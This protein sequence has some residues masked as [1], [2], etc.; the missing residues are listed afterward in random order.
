MTKTTRIRLHILSLLTVVGLAS[1]AK[2]Q[3]SND[4]GAAAADSAA[5]DSIQPIPESAIVDEVIW[6][7]GDEAILKSDVEEAVYLPILVLARS[8]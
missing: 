6:V 1:M 4:D 8:V 3:I 2:G 7:V 5:V